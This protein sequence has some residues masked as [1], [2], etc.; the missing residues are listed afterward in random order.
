MDRCA[1]FVDAGYVLADGA[2]AVHGTRR[3][4]SVSWDYGGLLQL[5]GNLAMERSGLPLLRCYWYENAADGR[6]SAEQDALADMP[7]VKLRLVKDRPGRDG[8]Q[9][10]MHRDLTALARNQAVSDAMI[11]SS[12]EDLTRV[13]ADV[14]DLGMRVTL[15]HIAADGNWTI[16]RTLRQECDDI[17]EISAAHLRPYVELISGA[18][19]PR[20]DEREGGE[21]IA[22]RPH[23]N[24]HLSG[25]R[26][27]GYAPMLP[28]S[29]NGHGY[30]APPTI[31][32]EPAGE[33]NGHR[34]VERPAA[35]PE[36]P[37]QPDPRPAAPGG[38][39][40]GDLLAGLAAIPVKHPENPD[41]NTAPLDPAWPQDEFRTDQMPARNARHGASEAR[42]EPLAS[43]QAPSQDGVLPVPPA[44]PPPRY[45]SARRGDMPPVGD[46][47]AQGEAAAGDPA[48]PDGAG[49]PARGNPPVRGELPARRGFTAY[50]DLFA[51]PVGEAPPA[52]PLTPPAPPPPEAQPSAPAPVPMAGPAPQDDRSGRPPAA[53]PHPA[54][55]SG[56]NPGAMREQMPAEADSGSHPDSGAY[57]AQVHRLPMRG[58]GYGAPGDQP[59]LPPPPGSHAAG[60][61][62]AGPDVPPAPTYTPSANGSYS[63]PQPAVSLRQHGTGPL[64]ALGVNGF[65][66][67]LGPVGQ[68]IGPAGQPVGPVTPG[69]PAP[70]QP[71]QGQPPQAHPAHGQQAP[72]Q[73]APERPAPVPP[74]P[75]SPGPMSP[76]QVPPGAM[77]P[78]QV[79][80]GAGQPAPGQAEF[81]QPMY[82]QPEY[83]QGYGQP[84]FVQPGYGPADGISHTGPGAGLN[85]A[86]GPN[87]V[88]GP[89]P[90]GAGPDPLPMAGPGHPGVPHN[91]GPPQNPAGPQN[92]GVPLSP[93]SGEPNMSGPPNPGAPAGPGGQQADP[94][95]QANPGGPGNGVNPGAELQGVPGFPPAAP[96]PTIS[97]ADAVQSA[98]EE[99]Q[100]FGGSVARDAPT[101]W[102][103]AVLARKPRMPSD[104]E[105]RLLQGST[106]PIDFLLHD[107]VRHA[108]RRGFW[109]ALERA[110]R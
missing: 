22:L 47:A 10:E 25:T 80:P 91:P 98:H 93:P 64:P 79:P 45:D 66:E 99:G 60:P 88:G 78:G 100:E 39:P 59:A 70:G 77:P 95:P 109:D 81:G 74:G 18:E 46:L 63:G 68:P 21:L 20:A 61:Q 71:P 13:V 83:T 53:R 7:G 33:P 73:F 72:G 49:L 57:S 42:Q 48:I 105:A 75:M 15:L 54:D 29:G 94:G 44:E 12:S 40:G 50:Q 69:Q 41:A 28:E 51:A 23:A 102:L 86:G 14:Q 82:G 89:G 110:R 27:S 19:P 26:T 38:L 5:L 2:M 96:Q 11:V 90:A 97:L 87:P 34:P 56:Y 37:A 3:R 67:P 17:V 43:Q 24:G 107:E 55:F 36:P 76:G 92:P 58:S 65:G 106:L 6:R 30:Q 9:D 85:P 84:E 32:A 103:E 16:S 52:A 31:Y 4:E 8:V 104:L 1:L 108:L 35:Q 62:P 101:L